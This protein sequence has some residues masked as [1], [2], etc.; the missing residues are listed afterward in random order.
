MIFDFIIF[1]TCHCIVINGVLP[2]QTRLLT[3]IGMHLRSKYFNCC[4]WPNR[5][6]NIHIII[7][8]CVLVS[9]V[10]FA[11]IIKTYNFLSMKMWKEKVFTC[12]MQLFILD[13]S[14]KDRTIFSSARERKKLR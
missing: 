13:I 5:N 14:L 3:E 7:Q 4:S 2:N 9:Y 6:M 1:H 10:P 8:S 12:D 11:R